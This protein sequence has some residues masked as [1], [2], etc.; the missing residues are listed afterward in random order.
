MVDHTK[1]LRSQSL[2]AP[3]T[4]RLRQ[5]FGSARSV[6]R[7]QNQA[8]AF[9]SVVALAAPCGECLHSSQLRGDPGN[10]TFDTSQPRLSARKHFTPIPLG[11]RVC[12]HRSLAVL[13]EYSKPSAQG[14]VLTLSNPNILSPLIPGPRRPP[15]GTLIGLRV[16]LL[17]AIIPPQQGLMPQPRLSEERLVMRG[18]AAGCARQALSAAVQPRRLRLARVLLQYRCFCL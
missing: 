14:Q 8:E 7:P 6:L 2:P 4:G 15:D 9:H 5:S 10:D 18:V 17:S 1:T 11:R 3:Q 12:L 13:T 16:S